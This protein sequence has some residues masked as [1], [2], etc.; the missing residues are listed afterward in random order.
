MF[1]VVKKIAE[2][3][4]KIECCKCSKE[5]SGIR[6]DNCQWTDSEPEKIYCYDCAIKLLFRC[7]SC[8]KVH[9]KIEKPWSNLSICK[10]CAATSSETCACCDSVE[11]KSY[12]QKVNEN[13]ICN[14]CL[15]TEFE[16]CE[17]CD[18]SFSTTYPELAG[19]TDKLIYVDS[20]GISVC[21]DCFNESITSCENCGREINI[22]DTRN[23][24]D[25]DC[26]T[27]C[28]EDVM[29]DTDS[30]SNFDGKESLVTNDSLQTIGVEIECYPEHGEH[31]EVEYNGVWT[32]EDDGS[33]TD[34]NAGIE[35]KSPILDES[36]FEEEITRFCTNYLCCASAPS[37]C[38]L[39]IHLGAKD[40]EF[41]EL[42]NLM[43]YCY[44]YQEYFHSLVPQERRN[45]TYAYT[46][47]P[48]KKTKTVDEF[49]IEHYG[50]IEDFNKSRDKHS[51]CGLSMTRY[52]WVNIHSVFYHRTIE[53]RL[54]QGSIKGKEIV[55][56]IKFWL[57][58]IPI[59]I[60]N[61]KYWEAPEEIIKHN[62]RELYKYYTQK[63]ELYLEE[64]E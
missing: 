31:S 17:Y 61:K 19:R 46:I 45:N 20:M 25:I 40:L 56:W 22:N 12:G 11:H 55:N 57:L 47:P 41:I 5:V 42:N 60:Q 24:Q 23:Y 52:F 16:T 13:F 48:Y 2:V 18:S 30:F 15:R 43:R 35:Y 64:E 7:T 49:A 54:H 28:K 8:K 59:A 3:E 6:K 1:K 58:I 27:I 26:C 14:K 32:A 38:G 9:L 62:S 29:Y 51:P 53:I 4:K 36:N 34:C 33:L 37:D 21:K 63:Q 44:K 39:H 50:T 10:D